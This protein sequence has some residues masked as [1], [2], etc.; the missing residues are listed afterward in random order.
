MTTAE[1][2]A[3]IQNEWRIEFA[4]EEHRYFDQ[5]RTGVSIN[6]TGTTLTFNPI[7]VLN[8]AF[9]TKQYFHPIPYDE[10]LKDP[11]LKQN[12]GW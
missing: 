8:T 3:F 2:R 11:N 7:T 1:M 6:L 10:V 12:P 5:P 9:I 4:F